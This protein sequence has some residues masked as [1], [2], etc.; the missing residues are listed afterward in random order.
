MGFFDNC[1]ENAAVTFTCF[2]KREEFCIPFLLNN[3]I[4]SLRCPLET[5]IGERGINISGGQKARLSLARCLY[6]HRSSDLFLF[7]GTLSVD[8]VEVLLNALYSF[9][10]SWCLF[11]VFH[12]FR[13]G[14]FRHNMNQ[15]LKGKGNLCSFEY[16]S[17]SNVVWC[18]NHESTQLILSVPWCTWRAF[19]F[20]ICERSIMN[21]WLRR[22]GT[23]YFR[24]E[25]P[26]NF[27][28]S[29]NYGVKY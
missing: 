18:T 22:K 25:W 7:D 26:E 1:S 16:T 20:C 2:G 6:R 3:R 29:R 21:H 10:F 28:M 13:V 15:L 11:F 4:F 23:A 5:E 14:I 24:I 12:M 27:L 8:V 9:I 19:C 17:S